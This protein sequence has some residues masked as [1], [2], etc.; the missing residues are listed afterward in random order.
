MGNLT[1]RV[2]WGKK[3][4][5]GKKPFCL[6][7]AMTTGNNEILQRV[8]VNT[9]GRG[10]MPRNNNDASEVN[11]AVAVSVLMSFAVNFLN[12]LHSIASVWTEVKFCFINY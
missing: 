12:T 11:H 8:F 4:H 10:N 3:A 1:I 7:S 9:V 5:W 2:N 6:C